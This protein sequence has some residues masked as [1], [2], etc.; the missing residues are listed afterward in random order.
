MNSDKH[1]DLRPVVIREC[2][3]DSENESSSDKMPQEPPFLADS[4][5]VLLGFQIDRFRIV[6]I[7]GR[8][9]HLIDPQLFYNIMSF[10]I[11]SIQG[12]GPQAHK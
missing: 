1:P 11:P 5:K 9:I 12:S 8:L 2:K 10:F 3:S 6:C 7:M 4:Y